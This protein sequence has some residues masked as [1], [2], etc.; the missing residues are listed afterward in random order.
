MRVCVTLPTDVG[1]QVQH[2]RLVDHIIDYTPGR[3]ERAGRFA[4]GSGRVLVG[5]SFGQQV[6]KHH[7]EQFG[8]EGY[9]FFEGGV[10]I[11]RKFIAA[12]NP[13]KSLRT[14]RVFPASCGK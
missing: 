8:I 13:V 5:V 3:I 9:V 1:G 12:Q 4:G 6:F 14:E 10:F 7:T 2:Q 11:D